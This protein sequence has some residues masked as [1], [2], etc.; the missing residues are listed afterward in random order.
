MILYR[1]FNPQLNLYYSTGG[2]PHW[3]D[4]GEF[5]SNLDAAKRSLT[6]ALSR[7]KPRR[8]YNYTNK[9]WENEAGW[10]QPCLMLVTVQCAELEA[11]PFYEFVSPAM[12]KKYIQKMDPR[13]IVK[14]RKTTQE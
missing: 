12:K 6:R 13:D 8:T 10:S 5:F 14:T 7:V 4:T 2:S 1:V 3:N 9:R 11:V